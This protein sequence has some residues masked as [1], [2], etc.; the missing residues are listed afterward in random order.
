MNKLTIIRGLPGS[1]KSTLAKEV[2]SNL[3]GFHF[4]TDMFFMVEGKYIFDP[5][6]IKEAHTW[7]QTCVKENLEDGDNV[8]VS[9]TFTQKWEFQPYLDMAEE[10]GCEV[11]VIT[12]NGNFRNV[13]DVPEEAIERMKKRWED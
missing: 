13:H 2:V 6:K 5:K 4:E 10:I 11:E 9:N 12:A 1:G 8:V 3:G 7:C